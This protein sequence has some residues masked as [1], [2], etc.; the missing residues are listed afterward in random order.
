MGYYW[1]Q[2]KIYILISILIFIIWLVILALLFIDINIQVSTNDNETCSNPVA[3]YFDKANREKCLRLAAEKKSAVVQKIEKTFE[4]N[5]ENVIKKTYNVKK[6]VKKIDDYYEGIQSKKEQDRVK[7]IEAA[8]SLYND[9]YNLV[10]KIRTDYK[11]NQEG[12]VK[13]V[14]YYQN[15]FDYNQ[16]IMKELADQLFKK[17]VSNTF[18]KNYAEQRGNMVTSYDKIQQFLATFSK[19]EPLPDLPRD[20]RMGKK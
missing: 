19:E 5:V 1:E 16:Q 7:K 18:T 10:Q 20:A 2:N 4:K 13:L 17:L 14:D 8:R 11:E 6:E 12:L 15:T 3:M 9:V